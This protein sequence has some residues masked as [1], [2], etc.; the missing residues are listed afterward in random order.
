MCIYECRY[1]KRKELLNFWQLYWILTT[2]LLLGTESGSSLRRERTLKL[3]HLSC[4]W[5]ILNLFFDNFMHVNNVSSSYLLQ[6]CSEFDFLLLLCMCECAGVCGHACHTCGDTGQLCEV[7][8]L[9]HPYVGYRD[10]TLVIRVRGKCF[11][12]LSHWAGGGTGL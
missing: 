3:S 2:I 8:S 5:S 7:I 11:Q 10:W 9:L 4:P 12:G 1:L 6:L